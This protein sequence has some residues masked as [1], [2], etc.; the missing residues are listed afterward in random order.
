MLNHCRS[1]AVF[2]IGLFMLT[3]SLYMFELFQSCFSYLIY[4][5][6]MKITLIHFILNILIVF[7]SSL[8]IYI[9]KYFQAICYFHILDARELLKISLYCYD[10][11]ILLP[12]SCFIPLTKYHLYPIS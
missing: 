11:S 6:I 12:K 4:L 9:F 10:N 8:L 2:S 7:L 3:S 1:L 5:F